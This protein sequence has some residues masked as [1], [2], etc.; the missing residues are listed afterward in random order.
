MDFH[1][2]HTTLGMMQRVPIIEITRQ[3][4]ALS[5][6]VAPLQV[7]SVDD[8][9]ISVAGPPIEI[10][11]SFAFYSSGEATA[12]RLI[13]RQNVILPSVLKPTMRETPLLM[14][15]IAAGRSSRSIP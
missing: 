12:S 8:L 3:K 11:Q 7:E 1:R 6:R 13:L 10:A 2:I 14:Q 5:R 9:S 4:V 15:T